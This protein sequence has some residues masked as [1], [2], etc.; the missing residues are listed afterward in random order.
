MTEFLLS[1]NSG[2]VTVVYSEKD[3]NQYLEK[4]YKLIS[5]EIRVV[6]PSL[7]SE[8][9]ININTFTVKEILESLEVTRAIAKKIIDN[10]PYSELSQLTAIAPNVSWTSYSVNFE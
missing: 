3:K 10:R 4:G 1:D 7:D 2:M 9:V 5:N 6:T 8:S